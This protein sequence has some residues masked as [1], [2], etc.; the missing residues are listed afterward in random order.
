[1]FRNENQRDIK[2]LKQIF[3]NAKFGVDEFDKSSFT[4]YKEKDIR[5]LGLVID[6]TD[7]YFDSTKK[8][9]ARLH[10]ARH[11]MSLGNY[12]QAEDELQ[13]LMLTGGK[14]PE[15]NSGDIRLGV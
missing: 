2:N 11:N 8:N 1:M 3:H 7:P 4:L 9:E 13:A 6:C 15:Y 10:R 5:D 14:I 12:S